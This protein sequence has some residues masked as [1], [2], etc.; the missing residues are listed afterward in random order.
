VAAVAVTGQREAIALLDAAGGTV[1][2]GPN[3]DLRGAFE[4]AAIDDEH[5][6][7]IWRT[8]GH[9][10]S[11][12]LAW[13]KLV[14]FREQAPQAYE[15]IAHIT[16]LVDWLV[17]ELTGVLRVERSLGVEAGL[18]ELASGDAATGL[19]ARLGL[20]EVAIPQP[21]DAG[22]IIGR[23]RPSGSKELGIPEGVMVVCAGPDSQAALLGTGVVDAGATG[24]VA[25]WSGVVQRVVAAPVLDPDRGL[26]TGRHVAPERFVVES[27]TGVMGG[28][29]DWLVRLT[30]GGEVGSEAFAAAD[31]AARR[32]G[33]SDGAVSAHLGPA[34]LNMSRAG[35]RAGGLIFPVPLALDPPDAGALCR[36][37]L[38]NFAFAFR[39]SVEKLDAFC[40]PPARNPHVASGASRPAVQP[41]GERSPTTVHAAG[42]MTRSSTFRRVLTDVMPCPVRF[43]SPDASLLGAITLG[44]V[45]AGAVDFETAVHGRAVECR[46]V[47]P[48]PAA[49]EEYERL[50]ERWRHRGDLLAQIGL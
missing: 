13:S 3:S 47:R 11:F 43:G 38:E 49:A 32:K 23:L 9:L 29:Y 22:R 26:W 39:A 27:N 48:N 7:L 10:P 45:A 8:T 34:A 4:G 14:W 35:L 31:R 18:V 28:A 20:G 1:Y 19:A 44:A 5:A 12:M 46:A 24:I 6:T 17:Y 2:V 30:S 36:A 21:V 25:G 41:R 37:A 40:A 33:R 42:G 16:T 15:R 50:Y